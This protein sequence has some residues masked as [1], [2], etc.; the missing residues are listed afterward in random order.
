MSIYIMSDIHGDYKKYMQ[1]LELLQFN[2]EDTLYI[3]GDVIDRGE[4]G[5]KILQD[6]M[7]HSNIIPILGNHEYMAVKALKWLMTEV[8][9]K[10][11][12]TINEDT[13]LIFTEWINVGEKPLLMNFIS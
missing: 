9:E 1:M 13:L 5:M 11:I 7:K 2:K 10:S 8:T 4:N 12:K 3:L 6:M